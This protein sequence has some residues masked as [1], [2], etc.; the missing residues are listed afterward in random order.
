MLRLLRPVMLRTAD[1]S[2]GSDVRLVVLSSLG[3]TMHPR[4]GIEFDKL[5]VADAG[6][7]W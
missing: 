1:M 2:D 5:R 7:K 6:T 3:H 4:G